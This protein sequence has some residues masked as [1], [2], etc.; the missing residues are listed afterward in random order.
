[1]KQIVTVIG[2][3]SPDISYGVAYQAM[4]EQANA[5]AALLDVGRVLN[6]LWPRRY[7]WGSEEL[8]LPERDRLS[9]LLK[10]QAITLTSSI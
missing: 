4:G 1:M 5:V 2:S 9:I 8:M 10:S 6:L 7:R 3:D